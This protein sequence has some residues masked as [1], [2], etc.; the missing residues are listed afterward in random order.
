M[1]MNPCIHTTNMSSVLEFWFLNG[2]PQNSFG[3]KN[4]AEQ[5]TSLFLKNTKVA[6]TF[7]RSY[8]LHQRSRICVMNF[9]DLWLFY[10]H[11]LLFW[12]PNLISSIYLITRCCPP[13]AKTQPISNKLI[14]RFVWFKSTNKTKANFS[15]IAH[16]I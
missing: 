6:L 15:P 8:F 12:F 16:L 2:T 5:G 4:Y 13:K 14:Q 7:P 10:F 1:K 9:I 11:F 3:F